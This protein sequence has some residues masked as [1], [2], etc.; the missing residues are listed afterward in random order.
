MQD[1]RVGRH[2]QVTGQVGIADDVVPGR[3]HQHVVDEA[4]A[5][6]ERVVGWPGRDHLELRWPC[7]RVQLS[8]G[9]I[10]VRLGRTYTYHDV[11]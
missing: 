5:A 11:K 8:Q 6:E 4:A 9:C 10:V 3:G 7:G 2:R 1:V